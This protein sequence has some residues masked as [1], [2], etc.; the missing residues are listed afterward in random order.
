LKGGGS[1]NFSLIEPRLG[2]VVEA[3][4]FS[5]SDLK[6]QC[7]VLSLILYPSPQGRRK[8]ISLALR[9]RETSACCRCRIVPR[10]R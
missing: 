1:I 5:G 3:R 8:T 10:N 6:N 9:E 2:R 4:L 7:D